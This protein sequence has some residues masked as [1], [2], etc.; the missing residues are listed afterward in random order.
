MGVVKITGP[1]PGPKSRALAERRRRA[2]APGVA[3][4]HPV[5][6]ERAQGA[7][8]VDVDG[9]VFLDFAGGI[10]CLNVGHTHPEVVA[11][12]AHQLERLTHACFQVTAYE[13][14]VAVAEAL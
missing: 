5:F 2:V 7:T 14:Y 3:T 4:A 11:A 10:G 9:N 1:I 6:V 13:G 12:A 8:V